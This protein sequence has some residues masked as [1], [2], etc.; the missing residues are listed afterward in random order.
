MIIR[1]KT[2][3]VVSPGYAADEADSTCLPAQQQLIDCIMKQF[4]ELQVKILALHYP[5][6]KSIYQWKGAEVHSFNGR[7]K[8]KLKRLLLWMAVFRRIKEITKKTEVR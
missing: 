8:G 1:K 5:Y 2:L 7:N 6:K 4:P 3:I